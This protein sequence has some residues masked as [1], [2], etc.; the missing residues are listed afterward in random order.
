MSGLSP[1]RT[2]RRAL[3]VVAMATWSRRADRR[4]GV[5]VGTIVEAIKARVAQ[6]L[7]N[8]TLESPRAPLTGPAPQG[9]FDAP[10]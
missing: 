4:A 8:P 5:A 10:C 2:L 3:V 9:A 6:P 1:R 7:E